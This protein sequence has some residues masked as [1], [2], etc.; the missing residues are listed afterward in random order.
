MKTSVV[1]L[2]AIVVLK[3][4]EVLVGRRSADWLGSWSGTVSR[5]ASIPAVCHG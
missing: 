1:I 5:V 4:D 3:W 2:V